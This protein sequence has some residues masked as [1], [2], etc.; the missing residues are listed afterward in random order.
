M[1]TVPISNTR[2]FTSSG[3]FVVPQ[4][5][6]SLNVILRGARGREFF[7]QGG[8]GGLVSGTL[9]VTPGETLDIKVN[10]QGGVGGG[11]GIGD[12]GGGAAVILRATIA[13]VVAG[14]GGGA[15]PGSRGGD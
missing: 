4:N 12:D 7:G 1:S 5:I 2:L 6:T 13:I 14:G 9:S 10:Y 8:D 3:T 11:I 15:A